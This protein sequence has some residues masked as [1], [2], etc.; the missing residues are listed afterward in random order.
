MSKRHFARHRTGSAP[1]VM[2]SA[3]SVGP[4]THEVGTDPGCN[5]NRAFNY[6][7]RR[8]CGPPKCGRASLKCP[9]RAVCSSLWTSQWGTCQRHWS[10]RGRCRCHLDLGESNPWKAQN[11][12]F[13]EI[14]KIYQTTEAEISEWVP[15]FLQGVKLESSED[16]LVFKNHRRRCSVQFSIYGQDSNPAIERDLI[17]YNILVAHFVEGH[18]AYLQW[19]WAHVFYTI[20][21]NTSISVFSLYCCLF[22]KGF[23]LNNM[24]LF[25]QDITPEQKASFL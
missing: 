8:P 19:W 25:L 20:K 10:S 1:H 11:T 6:C 9:P 5:I 23:S 7:A 13:E 24:A 18:N 15:R 2:G 21:Y 3:V 17:S 4:A 22:L 14:C 16:F 12:Y